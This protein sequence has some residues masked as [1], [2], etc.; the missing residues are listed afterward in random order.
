MVTSIM[1]FQMNVILHAVAIALKYVVEQMQIAFIKQHSLLRRL[2][3]LQVFE[4]F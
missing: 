1:A 3:L 4:L 2:K